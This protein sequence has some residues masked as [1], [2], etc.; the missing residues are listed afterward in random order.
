MKISERTLRISAASFLA[1]IMVGSAY[2]LSGPNI[3]TSRSANAESTEALLKA[4]ATK[5][6]D[7]DGLPDWEEALYGT[8]PNK[9]ISN[10]YGIPDGEAA[11]RGLLTPKS[12]AT[13]LPSAQ[14][15]TTTLTSAD[16]G[17][18]QAPAP[19]SITDQFSKELFQQIVETSGGQPLS[20]DQQQTLINNL[21]SN[22]SQ[23]EA[24]LL[25]SKYTAVSTHPDSSV[26][27]AGY[28]DDVYNALS[29]DIPST[30]SD[31][32]VLTQALVQNDDQTA[33]PKLK[34]LGAA[35]TKLTNDLL[36]LHVPPQLDQAHLS[37]IQ[38]TDEVAKAIAA[39]QNY[40]AD[41]IAMMGSI[42]VF[43]PART[44]I[45]N[46]IQTIATAVIAN[47]EPGPGMSGSNLVQ[48]A[49]GMQTQ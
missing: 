16:F 37:L 30:D 45:L 26:T 27:P 21:L 14:Q 11:R 48:L 3:F 6:S 20:S 33:L 8:D 42:S 1:L 25:A 7:G 2:L 10:P 31:V 18:V 44:T 5:D 24:A 41:P 46:S 39:V 22:Y 36:A 47:G 29:T 15:G 4:Y 32:L 17:G 38:S 40:K 13:Q 34:T 9:A 43:D 19:G 49:R 28:A 35:Y 12:L 23:K